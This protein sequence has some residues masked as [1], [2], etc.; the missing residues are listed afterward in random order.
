M[1][2]RPIEGSVVS[3]TLWPTDVASNAQKRTLKT[4]VD[5]DGDNTQVALYL[6]GLVLF[7]LS[8]LRI[9]KCPPKA[10]QNQRY[11]KAGM[12][13]RGERNVVR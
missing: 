12:G 13:L 9:K 1:A 6:C 4:T 2:W 5:A 11:V 8:Q 7:M 10:G 3:I